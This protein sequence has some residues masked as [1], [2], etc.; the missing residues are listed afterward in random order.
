MIKKQW[1][2]KIRHKDNHLLLSLQEKSGGGGGGGNVFLSVLDDLL[3]HDYDSQQE[4]SED[5][6]VRQEAT[7]YE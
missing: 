1:T 2:F 4:L 5:N 7:K 6:E 3:Y